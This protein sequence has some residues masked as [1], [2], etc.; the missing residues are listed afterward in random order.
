[1]PIK[2][3]SG[4]SIYALEEEDFEKLYCSHCKDSGLCVKDPLTIQICMGLIDSGVWDRCFRKQ[5]DG[6][7]IKCPY[8]DTEFLK[9]GD[10]F[11]KCP[12][13]GSELLC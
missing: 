4:K 5:V 13:C 7:A 10:S 12:G 3:L 9:Q 11:Q 1:M 2:D 8:C 6:N